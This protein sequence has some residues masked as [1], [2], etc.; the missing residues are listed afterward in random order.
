MKN[1]EHCPFCRLAPI[2]AALACI[3]LE[4]GR[5]ALE[6]EVAKRQDPRT[7]PLRAALRDVAEVVAPRQD[8]AR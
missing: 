6:L 5:Q 4:L 1:L 7:Q 8:Q 3:G 2:R